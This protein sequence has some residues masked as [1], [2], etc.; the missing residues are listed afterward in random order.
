[1][2]LNVSAR[3]V[4]RVHLGTLP[5]LVGWCGVSPMTSPSRARGVAAPCL[6]GRPHAPSSPHHTQRTAR[7]K[8]FFGGL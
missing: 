8:L 1:V 6:A 3:R 2:A 7:F 4:G 5:P